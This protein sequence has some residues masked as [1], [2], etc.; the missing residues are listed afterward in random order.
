MRHV[1]V[2]ELFVDQTSLFVAGFGFRCEDVRCDVRDVL[3]VGGGRLDA[4]GGVE[5]VVDDRVLLGAPGLGEL[6]FDVLHLVFDR[7]DA[8]LA[9][10]FVF[11]SE[12]VRRT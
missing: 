1:F 5:L 9:V 6:G 4:L 3:A 10:A 12:G 2:V 11:R 7:F 8:L